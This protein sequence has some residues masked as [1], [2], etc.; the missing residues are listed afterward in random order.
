MA[1]KHT[2]LKT[3]NLKR[4]TEWNIR[5]NKP[6]LLGR[7]KHQKA[8]GSGRLQCG[9]PWMTNVMASYH[10]ETEQNYLSLK[11]FNMAS[12]L[13]AL[14]VTVLQNVS[15]QFLVTTVNEISF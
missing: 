6:C 12:V 15:L 7:L 8:E 14:N 11:Y 9:Q 3:G 4:M 13:T 10:S 5:D 2:K 1:F